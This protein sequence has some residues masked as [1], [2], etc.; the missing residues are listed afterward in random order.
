[1]VTPFTE[2]EGTVMRN[3][4]PVDQKLSAT[5]RFLSTGQAF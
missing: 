3:V 1:M 2:Q 4:I 5:L